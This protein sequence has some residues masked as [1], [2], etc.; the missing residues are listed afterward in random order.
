MLVLVS[1]YMIVALGVRMQRCSALLYASVSFWADKLIPR[2][3]S[4]EAALPFCA[5]FGLTVQRARLGKAGFMVFLIIR[6][7]WGRIE[8]WK[9]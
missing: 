6:V 5:E 8:G 4:N 2:L 3:W 9:L 7:D 1:M